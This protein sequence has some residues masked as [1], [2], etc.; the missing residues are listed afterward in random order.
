MPYTHIYNIQ[1][2]SDGTPALFQITPLGT[3]ELVNNVQSMIILYG[4]DTDAD[5][6]ANRYVRANNVTN[7]ATVVS[8][9][10]SL[11]MQSL[12]DKLTTKPQPYI[13]NGATVTPTDYRVR[14]VYTATVSLRNRSS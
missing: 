11:L 4:I 8:V 2:G 1:T 14:R 5:G 9:R 13:F 7:M 12:E 6:S 10:V 3:N